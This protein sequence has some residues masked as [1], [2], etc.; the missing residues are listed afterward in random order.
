VF[1]CSALDACGGIWVARIGSLHAGR[2]VAAACPPAGRHEHQR[3]CCKRR[4]A[5]F[6][7]GLLIAVIKLLSASVFV[8][9]LFFLSTALSSALLKAVRT[10]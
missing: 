1:L 6:H 5:Q 4:S 7:L 10:S 2:A 3:V 8:F 9:E